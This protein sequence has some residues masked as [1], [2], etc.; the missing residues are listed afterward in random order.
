MKKYF[1]ELSQIIFN[2]F[3]IRFYLSNNKK[4]SL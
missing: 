1:F 2:K 3:G 4:K